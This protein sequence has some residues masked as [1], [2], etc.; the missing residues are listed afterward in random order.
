MSRPKIG[1]AAAIAQLD[2]WSAVQ[3]EWEPELMQRLDEAVDA[4][5][6]T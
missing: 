4:L 5:A 6:R 2:G 1:A 3:D